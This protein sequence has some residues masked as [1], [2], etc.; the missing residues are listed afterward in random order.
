MERTL[1]IM[2]PDALQK[3]VVGKIF[4][5]FEDAGLKI[6]AARL[7]TIDQKYK[8]IKVKW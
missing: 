5:R 7:M 1:S 8:Q 2:K 4:T 6:V 3:N